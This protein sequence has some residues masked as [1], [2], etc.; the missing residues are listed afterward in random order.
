MLG[1]HSKAI[2]ISE[3]KVLRRDDQLRPPCLLCGKDNICAI[4][5]GISSKNIDQLYDIQFERWEDADV[6]VDSSKKPWWPE[7]FLSQKDKY[8]MKFI[9]LVRDPRSLVRRWDMKFKDRSSLSSQRWRLIRKSSDML[10]RAPFCDRTTLYTYKWL[11]QN[12]DISNFLA[13]YHLEHRVITYHDL[14][15][16]TE[17]QIRDLTD[18]IGIAYEEQQVRYWTTQQH[19]G[20][21]ISDILDHTGIQLDLRWQAYLSDD[22]RISITNHQLFNQNV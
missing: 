8:D 18:F 15:K 6:V 9:H 10:L 11:G 21:K 13:K 12:R 16:D 19:G 3:A 22:L 1:A 2:L 4:N 17:Q 5:E 20:G 14:V 7:R